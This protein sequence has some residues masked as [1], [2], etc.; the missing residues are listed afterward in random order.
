MCAH[1]HTHTHTHTHRLPQRTAHLAFV[2][3]IVRVDDHVG[4]ERLLLH[5]ALE[6]HVALV[7]PDVGMDE[8]VA[9]HVGEQRELSAAD[10]TLVLLHPLLGSEGQR[11][12][13]MFYLCY[14]F[15]SL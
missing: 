8:H 11:A 5:K 3:L 4:L 2:G 1:T 9:L 13:A 14:H 6:A 7:G 15:A 10:T 12:R